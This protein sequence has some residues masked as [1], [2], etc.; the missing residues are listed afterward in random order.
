MALSIKKKIKWGFTMA[1][2]KVY[3]TFICVTGLFLSL[4][5]FKIRI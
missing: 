3:K 4:S 5:N 2:F 1:F